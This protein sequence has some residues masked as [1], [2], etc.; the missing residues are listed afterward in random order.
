MSPVS[1]RLCVVASL[2]V[3]RSELG[4]RPAGSEMPAAVRAA[5]EQQIAGEPLDAAGEAQA[6][7]G[8]WK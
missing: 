6:K 4:Y 3:G 2:M 7:K 8:Y 5:V 1:I